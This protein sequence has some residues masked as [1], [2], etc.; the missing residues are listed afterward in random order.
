MHPHYTQSTPKLPVPSELIAYALAR[1]VDCRA[2]MELQHGHVANA[3][4]LAWQ[5]AAL[6]ECSI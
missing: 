2:D 3:E 1:S 6:R 4:R 5:A